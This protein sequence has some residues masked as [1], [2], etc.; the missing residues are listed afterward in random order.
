MAAAGQ[1]DYGGSW[2][3]SR[4]VETPPRGRL[5]IELDVDVCVIGGGLA[6][7]TVALEVARR[8]WSVAVLEARRIAWNASG[9]NAGFVLPGFPADP[10]ALID[11]VGQPHA[12]T[13]WAMSEAG[14]GYVRRT[15]RET[16]MSGAELGESG[17]LHVFK[18]GNDR[19]IAGHV[20][21]LAR[22]F[23]AA[24]EF[25]SGERV[26]AQL[27]SAC[28]FSG[29]Y[30][31]GA[32]SINPLNYALGLAAAAEAAGARIFEETPALEIDPAGVRKRITTPSARLRAG[33]VVL[34]GNVHTGALMPDLASTLV[35]ISAY[36]IVTQ[37]LGE[38]L[39]D[40]I[41]FRG[42]V[43]D[44]DHRGSHHRVVDGDRLLWSDHCTV[45]ERNPRRYVRTL[46]ASIRRTYPQL[47]KIEAEYAWS[48]TIGATVHRMPQIGELSS[49]VWLLSGFGGLGIATTAMAGDLV[50]RAIL[51][52]GQTWRLFQ[53]FDLVWAG[54][55]LGRA[56]VQT[57]YW[58]Q[59]ARERA[60]AFLW[61][62]AHPVHLPEIEP[63]PA[64]RSGEP[65]EASVKPKRRPRKSK[66][67]EASDPAPVS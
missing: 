27:R 34:A 61:R 20:E 8:G 21:M 45:W 24:A 64:L 14:A 22:E 44:N 17:W 47:G 4:M 2:Y 29:L 56:A 43:T 35:P 67:S 18:F 5:S 36:S 50:A 7:L 57:A 6:G 37:P 32:F 15:V 26:R 46:L 12:K 65:A 48:G 3:A 62:R 10:Q 38:Q 30:L 25:W 53:P 16:G 11:K 23:G 28:Y 33:H 54:G 66:T 51:D 13:L 63:M 39:H 58:Y 59:R 19:K 31:P 42:A 40:A 52:G 9:R 55:R 49:G 41:S 60:K 1:G